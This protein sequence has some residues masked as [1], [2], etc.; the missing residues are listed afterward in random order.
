M[1]DEARSITVTIMGREYQIA[2]PPEEHER[3]TEC[4][5][6]LNGRM[7]AI[8]KRGRS[9]GIERIAIMAALNIARDFLDNRDAGSDHGD[10]DESARR[11]LR[12]MELSIDQALSERG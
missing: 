2:C 1:V 8:R 5:E 6:Y 12:Q 10:V 9:M 4:A 7:N 11:R 3:L